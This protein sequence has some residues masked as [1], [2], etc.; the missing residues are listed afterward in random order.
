VL[1][2][3]NPY[4]T[5]MTDG[6]DSPWYPTATLYRQRQFAQWQPVMDEVASDLRALARSRA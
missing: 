4:W 1:L 3:V 6:R 5:W 2:D